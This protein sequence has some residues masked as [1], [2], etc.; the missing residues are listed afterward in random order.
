[1]KISVFHMV[2]YIQPGTQKPVCRTELLGEDFNKSQSP[3]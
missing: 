1:M 2:E 3:K